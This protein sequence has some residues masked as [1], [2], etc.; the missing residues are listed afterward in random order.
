LEREEEKKKR[1]RKRRKGEGKGHQNK[2]D[3]GRASREYTWS[4]L[5][6]RIMISTTNYEGKK[7]KKRRKGGKKMRKEG[8]R[9]PYVVSGWFPLHVMGG[10]RREGK[11]KKKEGIIER[12]IKKGKLR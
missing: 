10:L 12:Q 7:E 11:K 4:L 6:P 3:F 8:S 2:T 5:V 9:S 1:G